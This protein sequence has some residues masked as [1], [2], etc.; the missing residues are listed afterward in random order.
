MGHHSESRHR[1]AITRAHDATRRA[2]DATDLAHQAQGRAQAAATPP[3]T[4]TTR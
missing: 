2:I 4:A 3:L 1:N